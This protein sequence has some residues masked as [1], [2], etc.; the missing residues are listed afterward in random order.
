M[1]FGVCTHYVF[2]LFSQLTGQRHRLKQQ[3]KEKLERAGWI[4]ELRL[5]CRQHAA[6]CSNPQVDLTYEFLVAGIGPKGKARVPDYLKAELLAEIKS[7]LEQ[8]TGAKP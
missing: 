8:P 5:L 4:D 6:T 2:I 7:I 3:A 1:H